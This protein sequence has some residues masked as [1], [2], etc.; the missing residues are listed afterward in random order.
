MQQQ[1]K[2]STRNS[3]GCIVCFEPC[4]VPY[5]LGHLLCHVQTDHVVSSTTQRL[6]LKHSELEHT[7]LNLKP[8]GDIHGILFIFG[9]EKNILGMCIIH[10]AGC[11]CTE[12]MLDI[13][14][15][16]FTDHE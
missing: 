16:D 5:L 13:N 6:F 7:S 2:S 11:I 12:N 14:D 3:N 8:T 4:T 10:V 15:E 1:V 9:H